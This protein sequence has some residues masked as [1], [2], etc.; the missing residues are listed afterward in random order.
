M[1]FNCTCL[2]ARTSLPRENNMEGTKEYVF[3]LIFDNILIIC[4]VL[5]IKDR[6]KD[7]CKY[8][9]LLSFNFFPV[10]TALVLLWPR[11][12]YRVLEFG[13]PYLII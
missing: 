5:N 7:S 13:T 11:S 9:K 8:V 1:K 12:Q 10:K 3:C 6:L 4:F 2:S